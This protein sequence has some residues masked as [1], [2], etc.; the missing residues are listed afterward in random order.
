MNT[1][2]VA[3]K[4]YKGFLNLDTL[5][6]TLNYFKYKNI[7]DA[8]KKIDSDIQCHHNEVQIID[9]LISSLFIDYETEIS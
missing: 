7:S 4:E 3:Y 9:K 2:A 6:I 5:E 1:I 8:I